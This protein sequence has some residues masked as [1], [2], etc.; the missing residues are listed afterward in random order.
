MQSEENHRLTACQRCRHRK[1]RCDKTQPAC[2]A[3]A[4]ADVQCLYS[5]RDPMVRRQHTEELERRLRQLESTNK[6][7]SK[8][9][10]D[11]QNRQTADDGALSA[12]GENIVGDTNTSPEHSGERYCNHS[13]EV[14][15]QVSHLSMNAGGQK[16][17]LGS[18]SG[19]LLANLLPVDPHSN[20]NVGDDDV[21]LSRRFGGGDW[22]NATA[23]SKRS[24]LPPEELARSLLTAYLSHDHLCY[25]FLHPRSL[26]ASL[27]AVYSDD[28]YYGTHPVEAFTVDMMLAIGTAQVY[29]FSWQV[30]PDAETHHDRAMS[31]LSQA[32]KEG[33]VAALQIILLICQYRMLSA[34]YDTSA[35]L[36][37]LIGMAARMCFELGLH[38]ESVYTVQ[39]TSMEKE[40]ELREICEVKRRCFWCVF[41]MD[42]IAST[43]LGRPLAINLDDV[44]TE[45]P[46]V[47][48]STD[49][50]PSGALSPN[51]S[52]V[53]QQWQSRNAIF[54][55]ITRY[56]AICGQ[57]L[58]S[59]H[60]ATK[61][62]REVSGYSTVQQGLAH[63]LEEWRS[64]IDTLPLIDIH[65]AVNK[66]KSSFRAREWYELL[67]HNG[68]LMLYRPSTTLHDT[69]RS[70][71]MLQSILQ[72]AQQSIAT[73]AQ[74]HRSRKINY[75][76][77]T[78][79]AVFIAGLSYSY[80]VRSH[81]QTR[82]RQLKTP[83]DEVQN[84]QEALLTSDPSISQIVND[85]R[86]CSTVLVALSERWGT[87]RTCHDVFGRLT[88]AVLADV[89]DF[90]TKPAQGY[91]PMPSA[92]QFDQNQW[93]SVS[94]TQMLSLTT[95]MDIASGYQDCFT[96]LGE[97]FSSQYS[98]AA[99]MQAPQ[100]WIFEIQA[101]NEGF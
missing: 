60:N 57:I 73:Y 98:S 20:T 94:D 12:G 50:S 61:K 22:K 56:R 75:S 48:E 80:A 67:Y 1:A 55:H 24:A 91:W 93:N 66:D 29:K 21:S 72:A 8:S 68:V 49:T 88:D 76:W 99:M 13:N 5:L 46:S 92:S 47:T 65:S 70:S 85:T 42:R 10:R 35:S 28:G 63:E 30:L 81:F 74:L 95:P 89:I 69:P 44:D 4:K 34:A 26:M 3:C 40:N 32:L 17:F 36:W 41:A 71:E 86:A 37:H 43:I 51:E 101:L 45:F 100:D 2:S 39:H 18:A 58:S 15:S 9:I 6:A 33:G 25:P 87:A 90:Y 52:F 78:L 77:I 23:A 19:L 64:G 84:R 96:D 7:L 97:L 14:A 27:D 11:A 31:R 59:L 16:Q 53:S 83:M 79:H 54:V 82:R 62:K 38:R